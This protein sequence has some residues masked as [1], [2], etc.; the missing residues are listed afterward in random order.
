MNTRIKHRSNKNKL[1]HAMKNVSNDQKLLYF[2]IF[3]I[4]KK[5]Y[6]YILQQN[7]GN[8]RSF[9]S[10][11]KVKNIVQ[12]KNTYFGGVES[13]FQKYLYFVDALNSGYGVD[14]FTAF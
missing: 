10:E 6:I 9:F 4:A 3:S 13:L 2:L 12:T 8:F 11:S 14:V 5:I 7:V 1:I